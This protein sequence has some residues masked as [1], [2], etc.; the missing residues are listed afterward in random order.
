LKVGGIKLKKNEK[1]RVLQFGKSIFFTAFL[2][3]LLALHFKD[4]L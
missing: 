1:E 3:G 4:D 2:A